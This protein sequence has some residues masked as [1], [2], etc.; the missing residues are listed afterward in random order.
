MNKKYK[1]INSNNDD[2]CEQSNLTI[3]IYIILFSILFYLIYKLIFQ[4]DNFEN[5]GNIQNNSNLA[6]INE[7][8]QKNQLLTNMFKYKDLEQDNFI[9]SNFEKIDLQS[10]EKIEDNILNSFT[11]NNLQEIDLDK[12]RVILNYSD[13]TTVLENLSNYKNFYKPGDIVTSPA[14]PIIDKNIICYQD[15]GKLIK[16]NPDF[17]KKYPEC[18]VC[19]INN[20]PD[21]TQSVGWKNTNTNIKEVCLFNPNPDSNSQVATLQ[22]CQKFCNINSST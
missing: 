4:R 16:T 1:I 10:F 5:M 2:F 3:L 17:I 21:V 15:K 11:K 13:L 12:Y 9:N 22:D 8:E 20:D 7:P 19:S 18:M 14:S 6:T